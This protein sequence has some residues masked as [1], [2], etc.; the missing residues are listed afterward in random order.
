M[1]TSATR[2]LSLNRNNKVV[3]QLGVV[4]ILGVEFAEAQH[5]YKYRLKRKEKINKSREEIFYQLK[6]FIVVKISCRKCFL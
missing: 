4:S 5:F 1:L 3:I 2:D 6:G